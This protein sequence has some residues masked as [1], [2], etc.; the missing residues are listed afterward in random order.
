MKR[1]ALYFIIGIIIL[2]FSLKAQ[3]LI[4]LTLEEAEALALRDN[5]DI[6]LKAEDVSKAKAKLAEAVSG[7]SPTLS[8][9]GGWTDT[10]GYYSKDIGQTSTQ[11]TLKQPIYKGGKV[12]NTILYDKEGIKIAQAIL[13]K[14]RLETVLN[15]KKG[16]YTLLLAQEFTDLNKA[17][18]ENTQA[19]LELIKARYQNGEASQSDLLNIQ[20]SLEIVRQAYEESLNQVSAAQGVLNN[21]LYLDKETKIKPQGEFIYEPKELVFDEAFLK[22]M[23]NR[24]EIKQFQAQEKASKR[25]IEIAKAD[26]RPSIYASWDY[27]S[28]SHIPTLGGLAKNW[29]DQN[30]I[31]LTFSWPIFD[32]FATKA[33]V[34][35]AIVDLKE[36]RLLKEKTVADIALE[37]KTAYLDFQTAI[38]R[39][40]AEQA[41][42]DLY[43]DTLSSSEQK[44]LTGELSSLDLD[45]TALKYAI[46][47]FNIKDAVYD[48]VLSKAKFDKATGGS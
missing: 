25:A 21:L 9:T 29:N 11:F 2:P 13:D 5:R 18:L 6:L 47:S 44:Y 24:P 41:Q 39:I 33:K 31:G 45:D 42:L 40:R 35:Q 4:P 38:A 10:R 14:T 15:L 28:K 22:A 3:E 43:K 46:A 37:L 34:D 48:Y 1:W 36:A 27:Y 23:S 7:L 30:I 16:F 19:H 17:I 20:A 32:G 26:G 12:I 8:F